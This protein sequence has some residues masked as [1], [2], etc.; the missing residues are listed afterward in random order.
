[1]SRIFE[2]GI[3]RTAR[4]RVS[5]PVRIPSREARRAPAGPATANP[6]AE[7]TAPSTGVLRAQGWVKPEICTAKVFAAQSVVS[8]KNQADSDID[9]DGVPADRGVRQLPAVAGMHP[10]GLA[11]R[12]PTPPACGFRGDTDGRTHPPNAGNDDT[13]QMGQQRPHT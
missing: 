2:S 7:I 1:M 3:A 8:Q 4:S 10:G 13:H 12:A 11:T 9:R 5:R 6:I